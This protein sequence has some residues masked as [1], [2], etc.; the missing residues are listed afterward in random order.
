MEERVVIVDDS[1]KIIDAVPR[2]VMRKQNLLHRSSYVIVTNSNEQILVQKRSMNKDL[3][4]G[5]YDPTTGGV[6]KDGENYEEN[7]IRE[8]NEELGIADVRLNP[9]SEFLFEDPYCRVWGKAYWVVYDGPVQLIDGEVDEYIFIHKNE[10]KD[11]LKIHQMMPD[12][13][14]V[15]QKFLDISL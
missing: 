2:S 12:G 5:Y 13:M 10:L 1:N 7:A 3:Y 11:F 15:I 8:L 14:M 6:V 4:P 9:L